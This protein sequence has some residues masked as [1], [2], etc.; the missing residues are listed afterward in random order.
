MEVKKCLGA[1]GQFGRKRGGGMSTS[2]NTVHELMDSE[3]RAG[4]PA[5][6]RP[7]PSASG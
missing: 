6:D 1:A 7:G 3:L 4:E 2:E 5:W